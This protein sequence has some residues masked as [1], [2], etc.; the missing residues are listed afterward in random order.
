MEKKWKNSPFSFLAFLLFLLQTF[1]KTSTSLPELFQTHLQSSDF[2]QSPSVDWS[3]SSHF[4]FSVTSLQTFLVR[5]LQDSWNMNEEQEI[6]FK[7]DT[8]IF[9]LHLQ[10][11]LRAVFNMFS[12]TFLR[13]HHITTFSQGCFIKEWTWKLKISSDFYTFHLVKG[14]IRRTQFFYLPL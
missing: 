6:T 1:L 12:E 8:L 3:S 4:P 14:Q 10:I 2:W 11:C 13:E 7:F 5:F 9:S